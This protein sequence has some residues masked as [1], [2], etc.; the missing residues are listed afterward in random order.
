MYSGSNYQPIENYGII[1]DMSTVALV[2]M[3]GSIDFMSF[4]EFDS[5]TI[6]AALVDSEK[7]GKF[8]IAP[9][10][11][12]VKCKQMY[13][14][15]TN[16]LLTRFLSSDGVV[17]VSDF[18]PIGSIH[19]HRIVRRVMGVL[20]SMKIRMVLDLRFDYGRAGK[21]INKLKY[22]Y[23]IRSADGKLDLFFR[24]TTR[25]RVEDG[26]IAAE[27][28]V[29]QGE[30]V[31]FVLEEH[32]KDFECI[33]CNEKFIR[34]CYNNTIKYWRDW[35]KTSSYTGR[36]REMVNRSALALKL[37]VSEKHGSI[38]ASPTFGLPEHIGGVRNWDYRYTWIRDASFTLYA[39][40]RLGFTSEASAF[41]KWLEDRCKDLNP[42]GS[43]Q[44]MYCIDGRKDL[45]EMELDNL[46]GYKGSSPVRIGNN[47]YKQLQLDIYGELMDSVYIFNKFGDPISYDFWMNLTKL[48]EWVC[49]NWRQPDEGIWE[50]R[51]GRKHFLYS[52]LMCWVAIDRAIRL[53]DKRSFPS[54]KDKWIKTRDEIY[55]EIFDNFWS[56]NFQAFTQSKENDYLDASCLL[57]PLVRFISPKDPRWLKTL[58]TVGR[59]LVSDSLIYR[60]DTRESPADG[61]SGNEGTFNMCSFWY[62]ECL[63]RAGRLYEARFLFEKMLS[64]SNH[65]GLY[66]EQLGPQGEHLGN[67]PQA[68][69]HLSLISAV[70]DINRRLG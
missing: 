15:D 18:M 33:S 44:I 45:E 23:T 22:G 67:F 38:V 6:F 37:L 4:P 27:F 17:E 50:V 48:V 9:V 55:K 19:K 65:L 63:S 59:D 70:Y 53:A 46:E 1:G 54:A 57:M 13:L 39:L 28:T 12:D 58:D 2:G 20:G 52:R 41:M 36:W 69:T 14:T 10:D 64:Y 31:T 25:T 42:D 62:I 60:Y 68:F 5:P 21:E 26:K 16:I 66:S 49:D 11:H 51:G 32:E 34:D 56:D 47:A 61:L 3:N 40:M 7:G 29:S 8:Q 35:V 43:L 24:S 30:K